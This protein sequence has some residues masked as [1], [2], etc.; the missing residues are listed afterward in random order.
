MKTPMKICGLPP[1]AIGEPIKNNIYLDMK[2]D[3][4]QSCGFPIFEE[5]KGTNRDNSKND[6]YCTNCY[7]NREFLDHSLSLH[8][9]QVKLMEMAAFHNEITLGEVEQI[10]MNLPRLKRWQ[11]SSI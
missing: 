1:I 8:G 11:M 2:P 10:I 5:N 6:D 9:M 3:L 7:Q 4:C